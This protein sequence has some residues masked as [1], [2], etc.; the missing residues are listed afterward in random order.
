MENGKYEV[1]YFK[2]NDRMSKRNLVFK[3][4]NRSVVIDV[5]LEDSG[6][7]FGHSYYC[8]RQYGYIV[9]RRIDVSQK[10]WLKG[11]CRFTPFDATKCWSKDDFAAV[12]K[13]KS[14]VNTRRVLDKVLKMGFEL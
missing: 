10:T 6:H 5:A 11:L 2:F 7:V 9:I 8:E 13:E 4:N 14:K 1:G 12:V 3:D